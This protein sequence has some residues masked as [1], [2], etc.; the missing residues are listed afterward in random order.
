[1]KVL[2]CRKLQVCEEKGML[3]FLKSL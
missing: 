3:V 1:L 2:I